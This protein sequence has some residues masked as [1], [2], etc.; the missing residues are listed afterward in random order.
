VNTG[1]AA[2][3]GI[4]VRPHSDDWIKGGG[5]DGSDSYGL[6]NTKATHAVGDMLKLVGDSG[7]GW[8]VMSMVGTWA[9]EST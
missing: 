3:C 8:Y 1:T 4:T 7:D 5:I 9:A 6:V 2:A